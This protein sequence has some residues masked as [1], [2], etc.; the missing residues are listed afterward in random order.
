MTF[1]WRDLKY[2]VRM[3]IKTPAV[4]LA[5]ILCLALGVGMNATIFSVVNAFMLRRLPADKPEQLVRLFTHDKK[6]GT[7]RE[8]SYPNLLDSRNQS[9]S[10]S[11]IVGHKLTRNGLTNNNLTE[12]AYGEMVTDGY[13]EMLGV[14]TVLGRT[15]KSEED[16]AAGTHP[17]IVLSYSLWRR[18]FA[19]DTSIVGRAIRVNGQPFTVVGVTSPAFT[20]TKFGFLTEF[21]VPMK[22]IMKSETEQFESRGSDWVEVLG[23]LK[24]GVSVEQAQAEMK[25]IADRLEQSYPATNRDKTI[26]VLP[27]R[28]ARIHPDNPG[29]LRL[30]AGLLLSA[31]GLVLLIACSN[32]ANLLLA[33]TAARRRDM[34][35]RLALGAKRAQLVRQMLIESLL[36]ALAGGGAGLLLASW[37]SGLLLKFLPPTSMKLGFDFSPD[38]RVFGFTLV[39]S[40]LAGIVFG[41]APALSAARTD[42]VTLMKSNEAAPGGG[43][44]RRFSLRNSLVVGQVTVSMALLI[45]AGLFVKSLAN[46]QNINPGFDTNRLLV[47][48]VDQNLRGYTVAQ[49]K[50]M[51]QQLRQRLSA[52]PGVESVSLADNTPLGENHNSETVFRKGEEVDEQK[53]GFGVGYISVGPDYFKTLG[54][55][56]LRGRD[57]SEKDDED[58]GRVLIINETMA[59][60]LWPGADAVGQFVRLSRKPAGK[61]YQIVGIVKDS[62]YNRL[63]E[64]PTPFMFRP[65]SQHYNDEVILHV[66]TAGP[67]QAVVQA[68]RREVQA[69]DS[70]LPLYGVKTMGEHLQFA[71]FGP[72]VGAWLLGSFGLLALSLAAVG[73]G[74]VMTYS[75][76]RRTNEIGIRLALG[77][78]RADV[79]KLVLKQG[80]TL[81]L[82]GIGLGLLVSLALTRVMASLLYGVSPSDPVII[83]LVM[84]LLTVIAL[85]A[86][87]VPARRAMTVDPIVALRHD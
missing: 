26:A 79:L 59:R 58:A 82:I 9:S 52:L 36:L 66:R 67:P 65:L 32:I 78:T 38:V 8:L 25:T 5:A 75:V 21:W 51:Q 56:I 69:F 10:F 1:L 72:R 50:A 61:D 63:S 84:V 13:F 34:A 27:E 77:A 4:A 62:K 83:S 23:R 39:I 48:S 12:L 24:D 11:S 71:L 6:E 60:N 87:Y 46:A 74:G 16:T 81:V 45:V 7:Y 22:T 31:V 3:L 70:E 85:L 35:I 33:R 40:A 44:A 55:N 49:G 37:T 18:Q 42:L 64:A 54:F 2:S 19:G 47:L 53:R 15:L 29:Q 28:E 30:T 80:M 57:F 43:G 41:L 86:C 76:S 17:V 20:G 14:K 68:V 73:L